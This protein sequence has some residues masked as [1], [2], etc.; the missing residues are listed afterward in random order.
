MGLLPALRQKKRYIVFEVKS[1]RPFSFPEIQEE[2]ENAL[3][4]FLGQLG[5]A[6]ASP[7][8][9]KETFQARKQRFIVKV[10]HKYVD[11][12]KAA[13]TLSKKIK[14]TPVIIRSIITSGTLK[15]AR[16]YMEK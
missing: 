4:L 1:S 9:L 7:L 11:E 6:K 12:L 3:Q 16:S 10:S 8:L 5:L 2:V 13:L 15:K 14:N